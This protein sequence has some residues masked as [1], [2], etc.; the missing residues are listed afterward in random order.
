MKILIVVLTALIAL[1]PA[2]A[3]DAPT[4]APPPS[5]TK[6]MFDPSLASKAS[7][8]AKYCGGLR[9]LAVFV[10]NDMYRNTP[11]DAIISNAH[12][13][14]GEY[15]DDTTIRQLVY[16]VYGYK[17]AK[18]NPQEIATLVQQQCLNGTYK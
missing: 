14:A 7:A 1:A 4:P 13:A 6:P 15:V 18:T 3:A 8:E 5:E 2:N 10:A 16:Y 12:G 17:V 11:L 9:N